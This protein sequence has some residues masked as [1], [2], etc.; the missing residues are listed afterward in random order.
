MLKVCAIFLLA[1]NTLFPELVQI[2]QQIYVFSTLHHFTVPT[3][4]VTHTKI[5]L[6]PIKSPL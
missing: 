5:V 2:S 4:I 3:R 1:S 6:L